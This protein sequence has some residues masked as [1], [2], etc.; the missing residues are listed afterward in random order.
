MVKSLPLWQYL[1]QKGGIYYGEG[2]QP[3]CG[4]GAAG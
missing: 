3:P 2:Y 1:L 4:G